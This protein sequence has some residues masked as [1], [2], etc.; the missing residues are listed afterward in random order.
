[1]LDFD[2][3][4]TEEVLKK[5]QKIVDKENKSINNSKKSGSRKESTKSNHLLPMQQGKIKDLMGKKPMTSSIT[6]TALE[7]QQFSH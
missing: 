3:F 6:I 4:D 2:E 7:D 1:M 5:Y